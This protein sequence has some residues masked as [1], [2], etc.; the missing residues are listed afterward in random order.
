MQQKYLVACQANPSQGECVLINR[1]VALQRVAATALNDYC[2]GPP[3]PG[4]AEYM[5]GGPC[6]EQPGMAPRLQAALKD[7][8]SIMADIKKLRGA[9]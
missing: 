2:S 8:N 9:K 5:K 6:S 1:G 7:L 4:D 3:K